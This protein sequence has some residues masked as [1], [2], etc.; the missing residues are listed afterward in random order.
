MNPEQ[1]RSLLGEATPIEFGPEGLPLV[2]P[3]SAE[4]CS[5]LLATSSSEGWRVR[6]QGMGSWMPE[7]GPAD[8]ILS[9]NRLRGLEE[10]SPAD[11]VACARA[12][13]SWEEMRTA[14]LDHHVWIPLDAPGTLRSVGS[15]VATATA[16]PLR[17]GFGTLRDQ[18]LGLTL[19]TGDGRIVRAGGKVMK[20]VA[21]FDIPKLV[22]GS[23]GAFGIITS[24]NFRLRT[25]PR[26][27]LTFTYRG[28]RDELIRA[29][30]A[31]LA[32]G[33]LPAALELI[34]PAALRAEQW[35]LAVR[36]IGSEAATAGE[37]SSIED[38]VAS[39]GLRRN[40]PVKP[41]EPW[42]MLANAAVEAETTLRFGALP[43]A[44]ETL[45][46]L[47]AHHVDETCADFI[48]ATVT[49]G[50]ARW[51]G[52]VQADRIRL[53]RN[54]CAQ[55]EIPVTVERSPWR[56]L[57]EVAHSGAFRERLGPII[58]SV[59]KAFDPAGILVTSLSADS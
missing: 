31:V 28:S 59:R 20:N 32:T 53:L 6:L 38:A 29:G 57:S 36:L 37:K 7:N 42:R 40:D 26:S 5:V 56:V 12:G 1:L 41:G 14:L 49:T 50:T 47:I 39:V 48:T 16:G 8:L 24:V 46:D 13:T 19:V 58:A 52:R 17:S 30:R 51:S 9:T 18:V 45:L 11:L 55:Q 2:S 54:A 43:S 25:V 33:T 22:A 15:V 27:D 44:L 21:G 3:R 23:F 34:S 35:T 4:E 10:V